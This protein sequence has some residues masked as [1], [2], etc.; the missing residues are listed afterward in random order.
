MIKPEQVPKECLMAYKRAFKNG[1][2]PAEGIAAA[3]NAWPGMEKS[4][5]FSVWR[6]EYIFLPL[7]ET[8]DD[9]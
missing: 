5:P 8:P 1:G 4:S 3:I 9:K 6:G 2:G 7:A